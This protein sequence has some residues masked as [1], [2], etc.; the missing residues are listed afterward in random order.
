[1][2]YRIINRRKK[3]FTLLTDF[4]GY[5]LWAPI[6]LFKRRN[7]P[8]SDITEILVIRTAYI[9]DV[10]MTLPILKPLKALY[11]DAKITFLTSSSARDVLLN[12]PYIDAILTYDAFWFYPGNFRAA[13]KDY[14]KFLKI[15][16]SKTYDLVIEARADI[17]DIL[18]LAYVSKSR[19]RVS[20]RAG[21]GGYLITHVVPYEKIKHRIDY[22]LDII[23]HLGGRNDTIEW[24][25]YLDAEEK[26]AVDSFLTQEGIHR[27]D[28]LVGI[29]PGSR[30]KLKA[31]FPDRFAALAD[32]IITEYG[33]QVIFTGSQEEK[34]F[35]DGIIMKMGHAAV[36]LAGKTDLRLL[37]GIIG[38][39]DLFICNDSAPLH[40]ASAMKTPTV[41][42]F[43]PSKSKETGPYGNIQRVVEKEFP[44]RFGCDEDVCNHSVYKECMERIEVADVLEAVRSILREAHITAKPQPN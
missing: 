41:A 30:K 10:I 38:K 44:C 29:H 18:L 27:K 3:V 42:I 23:R 14:F 4:A 24:G 13:V 35:I 2:H 26:K 25:V 5:V 37:S 19:F 20:Y 32:G 16:R 6:N 21:G 28:F 1:M 34:E 11:P 31:W 36:N 43:G 12:N 22:H 9:G 33:A 7:K 8:L 15:L 39:L 40:I 17:R